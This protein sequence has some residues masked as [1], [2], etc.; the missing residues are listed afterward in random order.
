MGEKDITRILEGMTPASKKEVLDSLVV[1]ILSDLNETEK[2]ELL[3]TVLVGQK[4]NQQLA[5]M[6]DY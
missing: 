3:R 1:N 4:E 6:V 2:R 5:A